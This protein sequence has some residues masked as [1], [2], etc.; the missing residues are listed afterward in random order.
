MNHAPLAV[1]NKKKMLSIMHIL[2]AFFFT[3]MCRNW[4]PVVGL[5]AVRTNRMQQLIYMIIT[6]LCDTGVIVTLVCPGEQGGTQQSSVRR[7][8]AENQFEL[9]KCMLHSIEN[10]L[11][12]SLEL[13]HTVQYA[14][15][16][17]M[18]TSMNLNPS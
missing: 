10:M 16:I 14:A 13:K 9:F 1:V 3:N 7:E 6:C 17:R 4:H 18:A 11:A 15:C 5:A 8:M 12:V 2:S